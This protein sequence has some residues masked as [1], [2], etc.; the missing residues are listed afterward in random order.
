MLTFLPAPRTQPRLQFLEGILARPDRTLLRLKKTP[1]TRTRVEDLDRLIGGC[2]EACRRVSQLFDGQQ[3]QLQIKSFHPSCDLMLCYHLNYA[4]PITLPS[5][6]ELVSGKLFDASVKT[7]TVGYTAVLL[8]INS[9][10]SCTLL[11]LKNLMR[12]SLWDIVV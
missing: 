6:F 7:L 9:T 10:R 1:A 2:T 12:R 8:K 5:W 3:R 4:F 11:A